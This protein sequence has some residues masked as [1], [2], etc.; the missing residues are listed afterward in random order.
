[1][2]LLLAQGGLGASV[3]SLS[4]LVCHP[5]RSRRAGF[6]QGGGDPDR[7]S[8]ASP[9]LGLRVNSSSLLPMDIEHLLREW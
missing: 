6:F 3:V 2:S 1:M 9:S 5:D 7:G 4:L 8:S